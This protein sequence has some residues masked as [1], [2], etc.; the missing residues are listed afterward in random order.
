MVTLLFFLFSSVWG[1]LVDSCNL[2]ASLLKCMGFIFT[3]ISH[4][5]RHFLSFILIGPVHPLN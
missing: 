1:V 3:G 5:I 4:G 2:R